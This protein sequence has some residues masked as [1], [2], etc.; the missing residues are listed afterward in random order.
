VVQIVDTAE[1][2]PDR[3]D[4]AHVVLACTSGALQHLNA[5]TAVNDRLWVT[6][7]IHVY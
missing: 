4:R 2:L 5:Q 3:P 1:L 6:S 7:S